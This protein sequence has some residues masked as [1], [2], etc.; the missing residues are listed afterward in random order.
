M[1]WIALPSCIAKNNFLLILTFLASLALLVYSASLTVKSLNRLASSLR[2]NRFLLAFILMALATS[3]PELFVSISASLHNT[4]ELLVGDIIGSNI[5]DITLIIAAGLLFSRKAVELKQSTRTDALYMGF[6]GILPLLFLI[7]LEISSAE[8]LVLAL[9]FFIYLVKLVQERTE[10]AETFGRFAKKPFSFLATFLLFAFSVFLLIASSDT[11]VSS[12]T[13][14][15]SRFGLS[16][17]MI[18]FFAIA[19]GTSLPEL[20]FS[21]KA[22]RENMPQLVFGNSMGSVVCNSTLVMGIAALISP[23]KIVSRFEILLSALFFILSLALFLLL[24]MFRLEKKHA[25]PLLLAY[26]LFAFIELY[27]KF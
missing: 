18:G 25:I 4:P 26:A 24:I 14:L 11:L 12:A 1:A 23:I 13:L 19:V 7:D 15:A 21:I 17:L 9:V 10:I 27:F 22:A 5:F 3:L 8:G 2:L 16:Q 6:F 20:A